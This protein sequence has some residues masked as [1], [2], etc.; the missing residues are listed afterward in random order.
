[1]KKFLL[2]ILALLLS[3]FS[4]AASYEKATTVAEGDVVLLTV[5]NGTIAVE[6]NGIVSGKTFGAYEAYTDAPAGLAP[7]TVVKGSADGSFAF[8][9]ADGNYLCWKSGNSLIVSDA[10][11]ANSSWTVAFNADGNA[12]ILNV[13]DETRSLQ[14]NKSKGSER[15]ACYATAQTPVTLW[16]QVAADAVV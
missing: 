13:A 1:M 2:S 7:L 10:V 9:D 3:T 5:D 14:Y 8:Q 4:Y 11:D 12:I 6:Y 15:F 16:K